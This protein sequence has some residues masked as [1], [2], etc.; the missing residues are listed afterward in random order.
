M[1]TKGNHDIFHVYSETGKGKLIYSLC[2]MQYNSSKI[3]LKEVSPADSN[4]R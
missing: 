2:L 1:V 3:Y 4:I